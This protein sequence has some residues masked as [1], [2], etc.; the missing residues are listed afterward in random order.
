MSTGYKTF[1]DEG[2]DQVNH[3]P[4]QP[5][6]YQSAVGH[7]PPRYNPTYPPGH[8]AV[9]PQPQ[10]IISTYTAVCQ[11]NDYFGLALFVTIL[12]CLPLGVVGLIKSND[13]RNRFRFGD[14]AG[15]EQASREAKTFSLA[16]LIIGIVALVLAIIGTIIA[17]A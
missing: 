10:T 4:T 7:D 3:P 15:A 1:Q 14:I 13:V 9:A 2:G 16:G 6:R 11:P 12:C 5:T 8:T 17:A